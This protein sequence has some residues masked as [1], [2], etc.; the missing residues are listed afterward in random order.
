MN[1]RVVRFASVLGISIALCACHSVK[2]PVTPGEHYI[3]TINLPSQRSPSPGNTALKIYDAG[4][5]WSMPA[6]VHREVARLRRVYR[7]K[8][9]DDWPLQSIGEHCLVI[10]ADKATIVAMQQDSSVLSVQS[11]K[12]YSLRRSKPPYDDDQMALQYGK[13]VEAVHRLH[14]WATGMGIRLGIIDTAVDTAHP[15]LEAAIVSSQRFVDSEG[16]DLSHGT[17]V[18]GVI[19]AQA[20]NQIGT[21]GF[22]PDA[23][24]V[25][26]AAC[27][28]RNQATRCNSFSIAKALEH[29][30]ADDLDIV[31]LSLAGPTDPLLTRLIDRLS[32][33]AI[34][35]ASGDP[36]STTLGF[37]ASHEAV[38]AAMKPGSVHHGVSHDIIIVMDEHLTTASGG[39]WRFFYGDSMS[40]ARVSALVA[41]M[42]ERFPDMTKSE[43]VR[44]FR[45]VDACGQAGDDYCLIRFALKSVSDGS[46]PQGQ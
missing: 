13:D 32:R 5:S 31:N 40:A 43:L 1:K 35:V 25:S 29:A 23:S 11:V 28:L 12:S 44:R 15:D 22:A 16:P 3:V 38:I 34:V 36:R 46:Q 37:P 21:V 27:G 19:A 45:D 41:L 8:I 39:G 30:I 14:G 2:E 7:L 9:V 18:A 42:L 10:A 33:D 4:L 17:A 26:Y 24:I 20:D 6:S